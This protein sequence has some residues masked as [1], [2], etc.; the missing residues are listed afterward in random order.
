MML[1]KHF[2]KRVR[3]ICDVHGEGLQTKKQAI[4]NIKLICEMYEKK[5]G[6]NETIK[7]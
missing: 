7:T 3:R 6:T 5:E 2:L 1:K 4:N